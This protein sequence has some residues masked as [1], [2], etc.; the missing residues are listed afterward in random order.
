MHSRAVLHVADPL[1][2]YHSLGPHKVKTVIMDYHAF[3]ARLAD[4]KAAEMA[5]KRRGDA[6]AAERVSLNLSTC[7][8]N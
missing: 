1:N 6:K 8:L 3:K 2:N 7:N 5:A 4:L